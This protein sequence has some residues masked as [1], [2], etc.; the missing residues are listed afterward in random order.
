MDEDMDVIMARPDNG[1]FPIAHPKSPDVFIGYTHNSEQLAN[2]RSFSKLWS[3][4]LLELHKEMP[5][6]EMFRDVTCTMTD[7][8]NRAPR[9]QREEQD[10]TRIPEMIST[11]TR[12]LYFKIEQDQYPTGT[13]ETWNTAYRDLITDK[14]VSH[15]HKIL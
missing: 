3:E 10:C 1:T 14:K 11:L 9:Y 13:A 4:V 12:P 8:Y 2:Q 6:D 5:L 15:R 7:E